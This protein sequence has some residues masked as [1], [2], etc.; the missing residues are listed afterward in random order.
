VK[1]FGLFLTVFCA[2]T[3]LST[4]AFA[5][6]AFYADAGGSVVEIHTPSPFWGSGV[7]TPGIGYGLNYGIWTTFSKSE[8]AINLQFGIQDRYEAASGSGATYGF[9]AAY[10][11][12]RLQLSRL[13]F[14]VGAT[15]FIWQSL[16]Y[17][18]ANSSLGRVQGATSYLG[19]AGLLFPVTPKFSFGASAS[20]EYVHTSSVSSPNPI[21]SANAFMRFYF[22]FGDGSHNSSEFKG[23]RYPF[24]MN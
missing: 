16:D 15:P 14:S 17:S 11:E 8:P 4:T 10:P 21:A 6:P 13:Y 7:P 9:M 19:E 24:G 23:W 22:G 18:G 2:L 3:A 5:G 12:L 1:R 20:V